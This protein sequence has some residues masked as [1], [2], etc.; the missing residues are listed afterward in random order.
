L[1]ESKHILSRLGIVGILPF[2][3]DVRF[4]HRDFSRIPTTREMED[5]KNGRT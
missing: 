1:Q 5:F 4:W 3:N 2:L